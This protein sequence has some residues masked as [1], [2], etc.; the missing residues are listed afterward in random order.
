MIIEKKTYSCLIQMLHLLF[1]AKLK[2]E[3]DFILIWFGL[4]NNNS[5]SFTI[6]KFNVRVLDL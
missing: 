5:L 2:Y 6:Y 4:K 1:K 3:C